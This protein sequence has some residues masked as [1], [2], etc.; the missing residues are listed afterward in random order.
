MEQTTPQ[1]YV[2]IAAVTH[3]LTRTGIA[4][5]RVNKQGDGYKFRGVDDVFNALS[6]LLSQH[7]LCIIPRM[8]ER[9]TTERQSAKGNPLFFTVVTAEFDFVSAVD[10]SKHT[11]RT[12]G[13]AMDSGDK[14]TNKAMSA[15]YK[16][17]AFLTFCIPLEG[18]ADADETSQ[19]LAGGSIGLD[20]SRLVDLLACINEADTLEALKEAF[21][22]AAGAA[23]DARDIVARDRIIKAKDAR[24]AELAPA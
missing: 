12:I 24:K 10:G 15:A 8:V 23:Q 2:A 1:V 19:E 5:T 20:P 6:P 14:A 9:T 4:K 3:D 21:A 11:A 17:A 18:M 16:Y 7:K 22:V 13:E